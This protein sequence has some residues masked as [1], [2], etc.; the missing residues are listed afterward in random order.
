[1][2]TMTVV[3]ILVVGWLAVV[4]FVVALLTA[5]KWADEAAEAP[6]PPQRLPRDVRDASLTADDREFLRRFHR[7]AD[8]ESEAA[9]RRA[10]S[11]GRQAGSATEV[12][13]PFAADSPAAVPARSARPRTA[14]GRSWRPFSKSGAGP[15]KAHRRP[16]PR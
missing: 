9:A 14:R 2:S 4:G 1:M 10:G 3:G 7:H 8:G 13:S 15:R 11:P 16:T 5:A 6:K 12:H